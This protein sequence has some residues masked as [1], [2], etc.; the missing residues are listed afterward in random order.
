MFNFPASLS[1]FEGTIDGY[2]FSFDAVRRGEF[3]EKN[4]MK[5]KFNLGD[6]FYEKEFLIFLYSMKKIR[7]KYLDD[8]SFYYLTNP[9]YFEVYYDVEK[10]FFC[11]LKVRVE[12]VRDSKDFDI[13]EEDE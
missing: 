4:L 7:I 12:E 10:N 11:E 3:K 5:F 1:G 2:Y 8:N 13:L 9:L 6:S